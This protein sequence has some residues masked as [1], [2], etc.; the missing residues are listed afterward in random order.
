MIMELLILA[1]ALIMTTRAEESSIFEGAE[2]INP[3]DDFWFRNHG[4]QRA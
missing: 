2:I 3:N 1:W 4:E